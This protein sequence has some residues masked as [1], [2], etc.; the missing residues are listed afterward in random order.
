MPSS[1]RMCISDTG[2]ALAATVKHEDE[3]LSLKNKLRRQ[4]KKELQHQEEQQQRQLVSRDQYHHETRSKMEERYSHELDHLQQQ[5]GQL[6][7]AT[8]H[9]VSAEIIPAKE[10]KEV[11]IQTTG[12]MYSIEEHELKLEKAYGQH[13]QD[14]NLIADQKTELAEQRRRY[15][16]I[17]TECIQLQHKQAALLAESKEEQDQ[18]TQLQSVYNHLQDEHTLLIGQH[19]DLQLG[20]DRAVHRLAEVQIEYDRTIHVERDDKYSQ[21]DSSYTLHGGKHGEPRASRS[22][23]RRAMD[24]YKE[25]GVWTLHLNPSSQDPSQ[26]LLTMEMMSAN[27]V[28]HKL[29]EQKA[30]LAAKYQHK[31]QKQA[32]LNQQEREAS[33]LAFEAEKQEMLSLVRKECQ[34]IIGETQKLL[35][36]K[37][38]LQQQQ[39]QLHAIV[40][41]IN[42]K[43]LS[44]LL[45]HD[46]S[47]RSSWNELRSSLDLTS[48]LSH[49]HGYPDNE[50]GQ[51]VINGQ[52]VDR[53]L[54]RLHQHVGDP[55]GVLDDSIESLSSHQPPAFPPSEPRQQSAMHSSTSQRH[56]P[57][58][59]VTPPSSSRH[60]QHGQGMQAAV[61]GGGRKEMPSML[62]PEMLS[63]QMT[64]DLLKSV[65]SRR[66]YS[67]QTKHVV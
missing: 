15:D 66:E 36:T 1:F 13:R 30:K 26:G 2:C 32:V 17:A 57:T 39:Q 5:L 23:E 49:A 67:T 62:F 20:Y 37:R 44:P 43:L 3:L 40:L 31:L 22:P 63:P 41:Q 56:H 33:Q 29:K 54:H 64:E 51:H 4:F 12:V 46:P 6:K 55:K 35:S 7:R 59:L 10:H 14:M 9:H 16:T 34:D 52:N 60:S 25:A 19:R 53:L 65:S 38:E 8:E 48:T 27:E 58:H 21:T 61:S 11:S 45:S 24:L 18:S 42:Q 28:Q 50:A 47:L